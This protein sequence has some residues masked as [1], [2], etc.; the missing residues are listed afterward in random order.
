MFIGRQKELS[1]LEAK[2]SSSQFE[3]GV[4]HGRR[5][6]GKTTLLR[7]SLMNRKSLYFVALQANMKTNLELFSKQFGQFKGL[8]TITYDS[9]HDLFTAIFREPDLIVIIDEFTYLTQVDTSFESV[10]QNLIDAVKDETTVKLIISGSEVGMFENLFS[11]SR[12]LFNRQTFSIHLK[13]CD[14]YESSLYYPSF[15]AEDKIILYAILGGL[16]YYLSQID[17]H[18]SIKDNICHLIIDENARFANEVQMLLTSELRSIQEYQSVL[19]AISSGATRM[20]EIDTQSKIQDT[21]KTSKY[22]EKLVQLEIIEK[23]RRFMDSPLSKKHLYRINNNFIAFY[24]RFIW[25]NMSARIFMTP[26]DFYDHFILPNLDEYVSTRFEKICEQYSIR[27]YSKRTTRLIKDIGRYWF[28]SK[29]LKV[30]IEIDQCILTDQ[31][32]TIY[33]CKWTNK[34]FTVEVMNRLIEKGTHVNA[35][36]FGGFS[37]NGF[38]VARENKGF[39]LVSID[40]MYDIPN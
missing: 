40:D 13:E 6:V 10:L 25:K 12:P 26:S 18:Q 23:E 5:R 27:T 34:P 22:I 19:L 8:G 20:S 32:I 37:K 3:F 33:E 21:S 17:T 4:I 11:H 39:D 2:Y 36:D 9:F 15:T 16:P 14:Y 24:Y 1:I 7:H 28:N 29:E 31:G 38:S 30:D 35:T